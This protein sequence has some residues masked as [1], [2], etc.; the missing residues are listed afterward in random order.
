MTPSTPGRPDVAPGVG[1][2]ADE[3]TGDRGA[4][5]A[6]SYAS[7][8]S[9]KDTAEIS[10]PAPKAITVAITFCGTRSPYPSAAPSSSAEPATAPMS[11]LY[12]IS[13]ADPRT[14]HG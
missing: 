14:R 9:S 6:C 3:G 2:G 1:E 13:H 4:S 5:P 8:T 11:S 10:T 7:P 12:T